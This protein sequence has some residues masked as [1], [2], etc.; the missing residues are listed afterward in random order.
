GAFSPSTV[1]WLA[2]V[3]GKTLQ[4]ISQLDLFGAYATLP[5]R[6]ADHALGRTFRAWRD[7]LD[8]PAQDS[9]WEPQRYQ[10]KIL[11][12][13][14][15]SLH[16]SGWY[17]D[18]LVGTLQNFANLTGDQAAP[19]VRSLQRLIIGPWGHG[20]NQRTRMGDIDFGPS[21]LIDLDGIQTRWFNHWLRGE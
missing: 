20:V 3:S 19:K 18:V 10:R 4:D 6:D 11:A 13:A 21:A 12:F 9:Y 16:V 7:W 1:S 8:H 5:L 15:P 14:V 17:D 2:F